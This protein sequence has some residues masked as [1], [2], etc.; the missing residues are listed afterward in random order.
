MAGSNRT[1]P[2]AKFRLY[3]AA[4]LFTLLERRANRSLAKAIGRELPGVEVLLPQD[5]KHDGKFNDERA[6][7][8]I[9]QGCIDGIDKSDV[10][11]AWLDG[12]DADSGTSFEVGYAFAKGI[13]VVGVRTDFRQNQEK[14][15]N[16]M[17]SRACAGFVYRPSFDED[18]NG[19]ARDIARAVRK[20]LTKN[21]K[22][23]AAKNGN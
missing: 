7:G 19:L 22:A 13:P 2:P 1:P 12:P 18:V 10:V 5:F 20:A 23:S 8:K 21:E 16:L 17:L 6:F 14:G 4:A 15:L 3:F 9:F 11:L